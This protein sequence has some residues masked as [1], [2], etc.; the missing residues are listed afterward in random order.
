MKEIDPSRVRRIMVRANNWV[1]DVVMTSPALKALREGYPQARIEVVARPQVADCFAGSPWVDEVIIHDPR[2][3]HR[4]IGG[5]L[6]LTAELKR[7]HYDLAILFQKAFG[8]VLMAA[9]ARVPIRV[10]FATDHRGLLLTHAIPETATLRSIHH[11]KYFLEVA[12][13]AGAIAEEPLPRKV[14]FS[15]DDASRD[16]ASSFLSRAGSERFPFIAVFATGA[17]KAPRAWHADRFA[18]LAEILARERHAGI[19]VVGGP[20]DATDG[21]TVLAAAGNAGIDAIGKTSIRQM[22]ALIERCQLFVG[23]DS[24]PMHI[25]AALDVPVLAFFGPGTPEKTSPFM[26]EERFTVMTSRFP[27]SPC[28]QDFFKECD[29][30][31]SGKPWCLESL[32]LSA[33]EKAMFDLIERLRIAG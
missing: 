30:A 2:G 33:A 27:C 8:A 12:K 11:V 24:G 1:G 22:A 7:R 20:D 31:P 5:F 28:R 32:E 16:F 19:L 13:A 6:S 26:P 25:A 15:L 4:G 21:R 29:P 14:W 23:N 17:S 3:R 9:L 18:Q 10:G